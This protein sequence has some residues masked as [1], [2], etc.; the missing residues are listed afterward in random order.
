MSEREPLSSYLQWDRIPELKEPFMVAGFHGWSDAG[1]V[2]SD[3]VEYLIEHL[4]PTVFATMTNEPFLNSTLERPIGHIEGGL[5]HHLEPMST[6]LAVWSNPDGDHDLIIVLAKEPHFNWLLYAHVL[7]S[8]MLRLGVKRLY[9]MGGVQDTISHSAPL[10]ISIVGSS[11]ATV[12]MT[13]GLDE[14]IQPADY[15][16][17]VSIHSCLVSMC[18]ERGID[19]I[20]LWGHVPAYLQKNPR[21]VARLI[22]IL[23]AVAGLQC[24]VE[25]LIRKS[26]EMDRKINEILAKDPNLKQFV[27]SM[28]GNKDLRTPPA[29]DDKIIR[30]ND[31]LRRDSHTDPK[32]R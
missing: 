23:S 21:L 17:P 29:S 3:T 1:C 9:T 4:R 27:E 6:E 32:R 10:R 12:E 13:V 2:S 24:P 11:R 28:E 18:A 30:L 16:G 20:S 14:G 22:T 7:L 15:Y 5:I 8:V 31:F 19:A 25:R 26:I